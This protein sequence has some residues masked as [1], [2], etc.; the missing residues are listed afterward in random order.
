ML[1][2]AICDDEPRMA[3]E[4]AARLAAYLDEK[5][6][7]P[8]RA[9][10]FT[11]GRALLKSGGR[12]DIIFLDIRMARPDGMETA[13]LLRQRGFR[14]ALIFVTVLPELVFDAFD[15]E[16]CG[17]LT[18]PP[19]AERFRRAMDRALRT[20]A[21]RTE[22]ARVVLRRGSSCDVVPLS[23]IVYCEVQGR[24]LYIHQSG[25]DVLEHSET[26]ED[27]ARR[28]DARFFRCH[29]S[30]LVNLACV[31]GVR[32]GRLLLA[33]DG[34][35]PVSRLRERALTQALLRFMKEDG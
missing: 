29:R 5:R 15:V 1:R 7:P 16:A 23:Q 27:F 13:R 18:K 22:E 33:P 26:L 21:R 6:L 31:R 28:V 14:G 10:R 20:L 9:V 17:Y 19:D 34:A 24:K 12:F 2:I 32:A 4:L 35:I 8:C 11:G 25:G 3:E 30:Y